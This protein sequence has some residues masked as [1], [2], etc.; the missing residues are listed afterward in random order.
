MV[1]HSVAVTQH[2]VTSK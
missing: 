1:S 2:N